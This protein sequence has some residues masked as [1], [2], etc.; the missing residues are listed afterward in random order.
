M[1]KVVGRDESKVKRIT[2]KNC[3]SI[4]EY[5]KSEVVNLWA[6]TDYGGGP[7]GANGFKCPNCGSNVIL[8]RW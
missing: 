1:V 5:T 2:C 3:A 4:L 8:E 7:D 6:G